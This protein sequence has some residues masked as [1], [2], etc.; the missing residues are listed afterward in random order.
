MGKTN[1]ALKNMFS[2]KSI[3]SDLI[4]GLYFAGNDVVHPCELEQIDTAMGLIIQGSD[5][6]KNNVER[7]RDLAMRWKSHM[8]V[9][10]YFVE[11]QDKVHYGMPVKNMLYDGLS[12]LEQMKELWY[13]V[14]EDDPAKQVGTADMFSQFRKEDKLRPVITLVFYCGDEWEGPLSIYDMLEF[15]ENT[16][17][18]LKKYIP[19]YHINIVNPNNLEDI[20]VFKRDLQMIFGMVKLKTQKNDMKDFVSKNADYFENVGIEIVYGIEAMVGSDFLSKNISNRTET[21]GVNVCKAF[22]DMVEEGRELGIEE[23]LDQGIKGI[24][25]ILRELAIAD[26][27]I[28]EKLVKQFE[29]TELEANAYL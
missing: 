6:K 24:V 20:S 13:E 27:I 23:G 26:D 1:T 15:N 12:Y 21:G 9:I 3:F 25:A 8:D 5:A 19:N 22:E 17:T 18:V 14:S 11:F 4:N 29:L 7:I 10:L 2:I 16:M 28:L